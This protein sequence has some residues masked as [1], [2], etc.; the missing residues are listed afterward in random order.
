MWLLAGSP[1]G[2]SLPLSGF[3]DK[4]DTGSG[5]DPLLSVLSERA[6]G[7][8]RCGAEGDPPPG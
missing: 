4:K 1:G 8:G 5:P 2:A 7:A 6:A 3:I